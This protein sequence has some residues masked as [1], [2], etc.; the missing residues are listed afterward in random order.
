M[1]PPK[2]MEPLYNGNVIGIC[3]SIRR[4]FMLFGEGIIPSLM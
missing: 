4:V 3:A 1:S 2:S